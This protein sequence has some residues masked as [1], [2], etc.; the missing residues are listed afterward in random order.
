MRA[1]G[2]TVSIAVSKS[3]AQQIKPACMNVVFSLLLE[4]EI[5]AASGSP[6]SDQWDAGP[7]WS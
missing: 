4:S 6:H 5:P 7:Q 1:S 2:G 3:T